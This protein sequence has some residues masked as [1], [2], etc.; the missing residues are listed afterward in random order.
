MR[1]EINWNALGAY[2]SGLGGQRKKYLT[3][4]QYRGLYFLSDE[5]TAIAWDLLM[6][7]GNLPSSTRPK[8]LLWHLHWLRCYPTEDVISL[9]FGM[10]RDTFRLWNGRMEDA[11][12][13]L[14]LV[15]R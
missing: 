3:D 8:H 12:G 10:D 13:M 11:C 7:Q 2:Y 5:Q 6:E 4:R 9:R 14:G 1:F 15:R